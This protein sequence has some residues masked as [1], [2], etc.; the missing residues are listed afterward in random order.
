V[1]LGF[2]AKLKN[3]IRRRDAAILQMKL[4]G[5]ATG[6]IVSTQYSDLKGDLT[7]QM[8][9]QTLISQH[10]WPSMLAGILAGFV[11]TLLLKSKFFP[12]PQK[13]AIVGAPPSA[14]QRVVVEVVG[15]THQKQPSPWKPILDAMMAGAPAVAAYAQKFMQGAHEN[16]HGTTEAEQATQSFEASPPP[17][18]TKPSG[19]PIPASISRRTAPPPHENS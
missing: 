16:G 4:A 2:D 18:Q 19:E 1:A 8:A 17:V 11:S 9:P 7:A 15:A 3:E 5:D 13:M 14:P 10:P 6:N 12:A